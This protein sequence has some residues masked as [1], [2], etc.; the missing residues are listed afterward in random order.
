MSDGN[1]RVFTALG[2]LAAALFLGAASPEHK[3]QAATNKEGASA[4]AKSNGGD[5]LTARDLE[6]LALGRDANRIAE[7][8]NLIAEAQRSYSFWQLVLGAFGVF[9]TALAAGA[10]IAAAIYAKQA[11]K[12]A[13]DSAAAD[14]EALKETRKAARD[15][16]K[17]AKEQAARFQA[18]MDKQQEL[19]EQT[20]RTAHAMDRAATAN[21]RVAIAMR[22]SGEA[23]TRQSNIADDTARKQLR[24]YVYAER[25]E[26]TW[27]TDG[28]PFFD[29]FF[30]NAGETPAV[31]VRAGGHA[32][33][34]D[35][36]SD[37]Q[38]PP[39]TRLAREAIIGG[40]VVEQALLLVNDAESIRDEF[41]KG[42][43]GKYFF[44]VGKVEYDDIYGDRYSTTFSFFTIYREPKDNRMTLMGPRLPPFQLMKKQGA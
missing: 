6:D 19:I 21:R 1:G 33:Y 10:A 31:N 5:S 40:G 38:I 2:G 22:E 14:N 20:A 4:K 16:R 9:F 8:A 28:Y 27:H 42:E 30:R 15:A 25:A 44:L 41:V 36:S 11:A 24:A 3:P 7:H 18:Q 29:V 37:P 34:G 23:I 17:D 43:T 12:A 35:A 32:E 13:G 39:N 26:I